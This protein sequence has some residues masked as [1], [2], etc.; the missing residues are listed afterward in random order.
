MVLELLKNY[1]VRFL[2]CKFLVS[3]GPGRVRPRNLHFHQCPP[4]KCYLDD[5]L[6]PELCSLPRYTFPL[7]TPT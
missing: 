5:L 2:K 3:V 1:P 4:G 6:G 7:G